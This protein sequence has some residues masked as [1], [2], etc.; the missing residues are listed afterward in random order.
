MKNH[1]LLD[2]CSKGKFQE[3]KDLLSKKRSTPYQNLNAQ[4]DLGNTPL[5]FCCYHGSLEMVKL[6][7]QEEQI[8]VN[9]GNKFEHTAFLIACSEA[10]IELV[11]VLILHKALDVNKYDCNKVSPLMIASF[12]GMLEVVKWILA[13]RHEINITMRDNDEKTALD[14][15]QKFDEGISEDLKT[16]KQKIAKL[17]EEF[18]S[19]PIETKLILRKEINLAC[20]YFFILLSLSSVFLNF[21]N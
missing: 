6:L 14:F 12:Y 20:N 19:D 11:Q 8:D 21:I 10:K 1:R 4:D 13:S 9:I 15:A 7:L 3:A 18:E 16:K 5:M 17:L 2:A